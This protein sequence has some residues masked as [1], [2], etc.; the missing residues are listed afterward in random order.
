MSTSSEKNYI[1]KAYKR[2]LINEMER[3]FEA[4]NTQAK[5]TFHIDSSYEKIKIVVMDRKFKFMKS[6]IAT[7]FNCWP[8][9]KGLMDFDFKEYPKSEATILDDYVRTFV[10][11]FLNKNFIETFEKDYKEYLDK[12]ADLDLGKTSSI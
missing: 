9:D 10:L 4:E 11:R 12:K 5:A 1:Y 8:Q 3:A 7:D 6:Y 2:N